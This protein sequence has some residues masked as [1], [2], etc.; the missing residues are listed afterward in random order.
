MTARKA[1]SGGRRNGGMRSAWVLA[2]ARRDRCAG[3][4]GACLGGGAAR[5]S[6]FALREGSPDWMANAFAGS[7]AKAYDASTAFTN[8]AGMV[9]LD[10]E[11]DRRLGQ[12]HL[13]EHPFQRD[14]HNRPG[15]DA[16]H[17]RRQLIQAAATGGAFGV[18]N[19][20]PDLK[21]GFCGD[22]AVRSADSQSG[23]FRRPVSE[24]RLQHHRHQLHDL[25][26]VSRDR[27]ALHRRR[28]GGGLFQHAA[29]AGAEYRRQRA[30]GRS[31]RQRLWRRCGRR[32]RC[33]RAVSDR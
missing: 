15:A 3:R 22:R 18:W 23:Q 32:L 9:R 5:A 26:R 7:T 4:R 19:Y 21:F 25:R 10:P 13:P 27:P 33:R 1:R 8:P 17:D 28:A 11:R 24:P 20:S 14:Q 29:D 16:R 12:R 30:H 6:G 2:D 31:G